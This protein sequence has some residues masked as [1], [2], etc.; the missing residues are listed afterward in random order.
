MTGEVEPGLDWVEII[1]T[2]N[3]ELVVPALHRRLVESGA[4]PHVDEDALEY[5]RSF[6][7]ANCERNRRIWRLI[8]EVVGGLNAAGITPLLIKG[9][10]DL[11]R[12]DEPA[13]STRMMVDADILVRSAELSKTEQAFAHLGFA[14]LKD[15]CFEHTVSS[16]WRDGEV[17]PI[18]L[19][20]ALPRRI[21]A[22]FPTAELP[23]TVLHERDG[24]RFMAP[25]DSLHF[26]IN[27][28]H[29][30][31]HDKAFISGKTRLRYLLDLAAQIDDSN[32]ALDWEWLAA[33][34]SDRRFRLAFDL[35]RLM[36]NHLLKID[37]PQFPE[38]D[39]WVRLLHR[40]RI[41]K[42]RQ[43]QVGYF[44]WRIIR[45]GL[46]IARNMGLQVP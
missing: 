18:D 20:I 13:N 4:T 11:A 25:D 41:F 16:Y 38:A 12:R 36:L 10:N 19:H 21:S 8:R 5:L 46:R 35:Q 1:G 28:A 15:T 37:L 32:T 7:E 40:R 34:R 30:I 14:P 17:A 39:R 6:D 22:L 45:R 24:I 27:I 42:L 44:E 43:A 31:L 29:D 33:M 23:R 9:G 26:A 3:E 2:A